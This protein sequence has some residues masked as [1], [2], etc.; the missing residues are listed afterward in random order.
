MQSTPGAGTCLTLEACFPIADADAVADLASDIAQGRLAHAVAGRR[1]AP[2]I[3]HAER[4]GTLVLVID[5]H[6]TNR[7][8]LSRQVTALGY[9]VLTA[10]DGEEGLA[11][12]RSR[13][14]ALVL[15]D[16]NMPRLS[17]YDFARAVRAMEAGAGATHLP[18]IGCTAN[19]MS[20]EAARCVAAGMDECMVKPVDLRDLMERLDLWLPLPVAEPLP[21]LAAGGASPGREP[22]DVSMLELITAGDAA[23]ER[24]LL[25]DFLRSNAADLAALQLA[26]DAGDDRHAAL[27]VHRIAGAAQT[28]GA[29]DFLAA[30]RAL[31]AA[32]GQATARSS[33]QALQSCAV[34]L[35]ESLRRRVEAKAA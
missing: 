5:D 31:H 13:R 34:A 20:T 21:L 35:E 33:L 3:T 23:L 1:L 16:C 26:M 8:V 11:L 30:C 9:S 12:C 14:I 17:G 24:E 27:Q 29:A 15:T 7:L 2:S 10:E 22:F 32:L 6:P 25:E 4:E 19:A 28:L 18:I